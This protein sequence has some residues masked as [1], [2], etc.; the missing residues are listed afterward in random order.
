MNQIL[1]PIYRTSALLFMACIVLCQDVSAASKKVSFKAEYSYR[2]YTSH[3]GLHHLMLDNLFQDSRGFIWMGTYKGFAR[4]D[5]FTFKPFLSETMENILR[6]E[7]AGNGAVRAFSETCCYVVDRNDSLRRVLLTDSLSLNSYNSS[8]LPPGYLAYR[9]HSSRN[10]YLMQLR[11]DSLAEV[12]RLPELNQTGNNRLWMDTVRNRL[13][14][15]TK[16]YLAVYDMKHKTTARIENGSIES[17]LP[18]SRLGLLAIGSDGIYQVAGNKLALLTPYRFPML[19]KQMLESP[20]GD[21]IIRDFLSLYR[22]RNGKVDVLHHDPDLP[23]WHMLLDQ[24]GNLWVAT[25]NGLYNFFRFDFKNYYFDGHSIKSIVEDAKGNYW[26]AG[27]NEELFRL[28]GEKAERINYPVLPGLTTTSF[29]YGSASID[30]KLYFPRRNGIL[31]HDEESFRW[32][33]VPVEYNYKRI[34]PYREGTAISAL[35]AVLIT[36]SDGQVMRRLETKE[37]GQDKIYDVAVDS[38]KRL[39]ACGEKGLSIIDNRIKLAGGENTKTSYVMAADAEGRIWSASANRLNLLT[40]EDSVVTVHCFRNNI[41]VGLRDVGEGQLLIAMLRGFYLFDL[42]AYFDKGVIQMLYYDHNN[43]MIGLEPV[44]NALYVDNDGRVWMPTTE[45]VVS[46]E[47]LK[48]LRKRQSPGLVIQ[49]CEFSKDN[50]QWQHFPESKGATDQPVFRHSFRNFRFSFIGLSYSA[51]GNVRYSYRLKGFQEEW[52]SP[53]TGREA[54][55][56]NLPPGKYVFEIYTDAGT[57]DTRSSVQS[58][59]FTIRPA[60]WQQ[61]WFM[62]AML[63]LLAASSAGIAIRYQRRRTRLQMEQLETEK[64]LNDLR[65]RSIRL[66]A[67]P[68]F[69]SNVLSAIEYF[70]LTKPKDEANR[71]LNIYSRFTGLTLRE[72]DKASRSL[73]EEIEYVT[74][75]L[76]LEKLRFGEKFDYRIDVDPQVDKNI[77]LPTMILHTYCENAVKH[78]FSDITAGGMLVIAASS[79]G[80]SAEISIQDNGIGRE[81]AA[82]RGTP[83]TKQG[84]DILSRQIEIYNS[85]NEKKIRQTVIDLFHEDGSPAGTRFTIEVP[86]KFVYG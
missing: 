19:N 41:I 6:I 66:K 26:L 78:G 3:D 20:E 35:E 54:V 77:Q 58:I 51:G 8:L 22:Y 60:F 85:F 59:P 80:D 9:S 52:S 46:F 71:L 38:R 84:L 40:K 57:R 31:L 76:K 24:E 12:L 55:F 65:I 70:I 11:G 73:S 10:K 50:V 49:T 30:R 86:Y 83:G 37:L 67:I 68:H 53:E 48:L 75:Y 33:D 42:H 64:A 25:G 36:G 15:P 27:L 34:I 4:F 47:P 82:R 44:I 17:F 69:N 74:L 32:A 1:S 56:N 7:D 21:L 5:G 16:H 2:R 62:P 43:G 61:A 79:K 63:L 45:C 29:S 28:S 23:M 18:H 39:I 81:V 14:I 13:Y 72:V